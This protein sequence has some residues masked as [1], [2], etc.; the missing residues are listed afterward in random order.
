MLTY[1]FKR[2]I[3]YYSKRETGWNEIKVTIVTCISNLGKTID[4]RNE[5]DT[6][7]PKLKSSGLAIALVV[8]I[9]PVIV[10]SILPATVVAELELNS[11]IPPPDTVEEGCK[12]LIP[13]TSA[14]HA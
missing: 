5:V 4:A 1:F 8:I 3:L 11:V 14:I 2:S 13:P 12:S 9:T 7:V 10:G 6:A